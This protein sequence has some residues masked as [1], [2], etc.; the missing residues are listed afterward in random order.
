M[1]RWHT[2]RI[3][4]RKSAGFLPD[5]QHSSTEHPSLEQTSEALLVRCKPSDVQFSA[6][7]SK[8]QNV[9]KTTAGVGVEVKTT[10]AANIKRLN[11]RK[12][13]SIIKSKEKKRDTERETN[14]QKNSQGELHSDAV[15]RTSA[16]DTLPLLTFG[17]FGAKPAY[18]L[19]FT[20]SE[21][22]VG[23]EGTFLF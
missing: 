10:G 16:H 14:T 6:A 13:A 23:I 21:S 11:R 19:Q 17:G 8:T 3:T 12:I 18:W 9:A 20:A 15:H 1:A 4:K 7:K 22:H 2:E 5:K